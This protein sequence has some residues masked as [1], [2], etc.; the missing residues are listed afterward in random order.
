MVQCSL[1][2]SGMTHDELVDYFA[3]LSKNELLHLSFVR[4]KSMK[5]VLMRD[6][7]HVWQAGFGDIIETCLH[8][9]QL[10]L[11]KRA[12]RKYED[13]ELPHV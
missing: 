10:E 6:Y 12:L 3:C 2:F 13:E 11:S 8:H 1:D 7:G 5:M 9:S 4:D